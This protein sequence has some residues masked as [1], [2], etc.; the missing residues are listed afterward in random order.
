MITNQI[1]PNIHFTDGTKIKIVEEAKYLGC[2]LNDT[3][4]YRKEIGKRISNTLIMLKKL[5][6][7]WLHSNCPAKFKLIA[8]DAVI[9]TKL[10]YGMD[11]AQLGEG[12][13]ERLDTIQ[14]QISRKILGLKTTFVDRENSNRKIW[15]DV[16]NKLSAEGQ[17]RKLYHLDKRMQKQDQIHWQASF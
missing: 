11:S 10:L 3:S 8:A 5:N 9:R 17:R 7:F 4:N 13:L 2:N 6:I 1:N 12:E 16:N 15:N 14:L